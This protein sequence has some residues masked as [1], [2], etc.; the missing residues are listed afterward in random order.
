MREA[1]SDL[2]TSS[3]ASNKH[4]V[5]LSG[6]HGYALFNQIREKHPA[7]F[8]NVGVMEQAMVGIASGLA[9][10]G[11]IPLVYG[12]SAF[13]PV[14]VLEQIKLDVCYS[15]L[16]V[17]FLG[18]GAG[19]VYSTLGASHQC[20][21]DIACLAPLPLIQIYSPCD[22]EELRVCY[23]E[24]MEYDG[25]TYIRIGKSDRPAVHSSP[26]TS[27]EPHFT[28]SIGKNKSLCL[29]STGSMVSVAHS[30]AAKLGLP[31][32]S[33]PRPKPL[34]ESLLEKVSGF[35]TLVV[36][37][38]HSRHGGL[39]S[40]IS[41]LYSDQGQRAP[42]IRSIALEE[43]FALRCGSYNYALSEHD[44]ADEQILARVSKMIS[45]DR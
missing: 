19:L 12:L 24:S 25:P 42:L 28:Q 15:E 22:T 11:H 13:V 3:A 30:V 1:L 45:K 5:V 23:R 39:A 33:V 7:Q 27:T 44:L 6:D 43:K 16:P 2:I 37:E 31:S 17:H 4:F 20:G 34:H 29:V 32:L 10:T 38:E 41:T 21:E 26:L 36:I 18:D 35:E 9:K 8:F 14:R 40:L